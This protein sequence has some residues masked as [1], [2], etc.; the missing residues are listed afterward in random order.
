MDQTRIF[1]HS[2]PSG[3]IHLNLGNLT[4]NMTRDDFLEF[5]RRTSE[6]ANLMKGERP[7]LVLEF[8]RKN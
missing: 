2:C 5:A 8:N 6:Y 4:I 7:G 1:F 3:C